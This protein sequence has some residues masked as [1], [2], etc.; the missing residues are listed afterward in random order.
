MIVDTI[1]LPLQISDEFFDV[2]DRL[3][4]AD[5]TVL[6]QAENMSSSASRSVR[7][8]FLKI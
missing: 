6:E 1:H 4:D 2:I 5:N 7:N 8:S 3:A